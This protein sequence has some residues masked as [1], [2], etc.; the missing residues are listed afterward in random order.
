M[1]EDH[2]QARGH[3]RDL[4]DA[5]KTKDEVGVV[6]YLSSYRDLLNEHIRKE[7]EILYLW[8]DRNFSIK[9]IG[10]LFSRFNEVDEISGNEVTERCETFVNQLESKQTSKKEV[11]QWKV[12]QVQ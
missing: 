1:L 9:Q 4:L 10:E 5:L 12:A 6:K 7:D 3:V 11:G 2:T 8:M